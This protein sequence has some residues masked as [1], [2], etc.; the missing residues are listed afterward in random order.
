MQ[1]CDVSDSTHSHQ[2]LGELCKVRQRLLSV[3]GLAVAR[4]R[5]WQQPLVDQRIKAEH[6]AVVLT[7]I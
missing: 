4:K 7:K 6:G 1:V 2:V 5:R 3:L